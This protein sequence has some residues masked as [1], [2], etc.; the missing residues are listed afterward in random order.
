MGIDGNAVQV[1]GNQFLERRW[2]ARAGTFGREHETRCGCI[3]FD[4]GADRASARNRRVGQQ[5]Q[6]EHQLDQ[7]L[8]H[9]RL[10]RLPGELSLLSFHVAPRHLLGIGQ[11]DLGPG[12][13]GGT[14]CEPRELQFRRSLRGAAPD[15]S[16]SEFTHVLAVVLIQHLQPVDD[17]ADRRDDIVA[18]P[19]AEQRGKVKSIQFAIRHRAPIW[20][21]GHHW[22]TDIAAF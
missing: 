21:V 15:E 8:G 13:T 4:A 1:T 3:S 16:K 20:S 6:I 7:I 12:R 11:V 18:N 14:E 5:D 17:C 9:Q 19:A 2:N 22:W 10:G